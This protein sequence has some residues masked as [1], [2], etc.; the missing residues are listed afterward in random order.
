MDLIVACGDN[1][2]YV[3][4][5]EPEVYGVYLPGNVA[6]DV[7][8]KLATPPRRFFSAQWINVSTGEW[9]EAVR[10]I[11]GEK[12]M[13]LSPPPFESGYGWAVVVRLESRRW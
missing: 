5:R 12:G 11:K 7:W 6:G 10:G 13:I 9:G 8:V 2:A 4:A 3:M 1:D